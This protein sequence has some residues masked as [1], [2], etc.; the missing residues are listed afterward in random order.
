MEILNNLLLYEKLDGGFMELEV[1]RF[2]G[3]RLVYEV[4]KKFE[5]QARARFTSNPYQ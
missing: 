3:V 2:P 4:T 5:I 1:E